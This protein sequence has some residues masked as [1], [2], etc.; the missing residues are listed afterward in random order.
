[1]WWTRHNANLQHVLHFHTASTISR[2]FPAFPSLFSTVP[3]SFNIHQEPFRS[4][5]SHCRLTRPDCAGPTSRAAQAL[6]SDWRRGACRGV[7]PSS[8]RGGAVPCHVIAHRRKGSSDPGSLRPMAARRRRGGVVMRRRRGGARDSSNPWRCDTQDQAT[9][10]SEA[11]RVP[12]VT[13]VVLRW[14]NEE[15]G[16]LFLSYLSPPLQKMEW[17][18]HC[19]LETRNM[20]HSVL[21]FHICYF[22]WV[23]NIYWG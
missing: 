20:M 3:S 16:V 13:V 4:R 7:S 8:A 15:R 1:M 5:W 12:G 18:L 11:R 14:C 10:A 9:S 2:W 22:C 6:P 19:M 21:P 17:L 23:C